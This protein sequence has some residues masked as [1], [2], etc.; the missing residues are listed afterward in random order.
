MCTGRIDLAFVIRAFAKGAD[1]VFIAGCHLNECNYSTQGNFYA[2]SMVALCKLIM[3]EIG[4]N[5]ER[6]FITLISG[7][8][9]SRFADVV[10]AF[11]KR[12]FELGAIGTSEGIEQD[13]LASR[14]DEVAR[15]VP[16]IKVEKS[17]KL[18]TRLG[19]EEEYQH[20]FSREE[21]QDLLRRPASYYIDPQ[22]C[23]ACTVCAK[24]CPVGAIDGGKNLIHV[25]DQ[26]KCIKCGCCLQACPPLFSAV[27]KLSDG[28][29]PS[30]I[31]EDQRT[32]TR[33]KKPSGR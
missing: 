31:P 32:I 14:L 11:S 20:L 1:G 8:E 23:Q 27:T 16:Y 2:L 17:D 7:S 29:V 5:K 6:L 26:G 4:I 22:K 13:E 24:R 3:E 28:P 33:K 12:I 25:I 10:N 15:L 30:P 19:S 9:G 21:V 18:Q